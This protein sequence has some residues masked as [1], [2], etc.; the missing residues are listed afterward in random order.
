MFKKRM[1]NFNQLINASQEKSCLNAKPQFVL[2]K[3]YAKKFNTCTLKT[4]I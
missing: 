3:G 1:H 2:L 4:K